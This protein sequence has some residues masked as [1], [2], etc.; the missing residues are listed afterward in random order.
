MKEQPLF[1]IATISY[2]SEKWIRQAIESVLASSISDFEYL[3]SD[4]CSSD[5][6]WNIVSQ[7]NDPRIRSWKNEQNIG[8]YPNRNK[9]L[10]EAKGKYILYV[11]GDDILYNNTLR[12]ASEYVFAFP[13]AVSLW[14]V[15]SHELSFCIFPVL[16]QPAEL[17]KWIYGANLPIAIM[18]FGETVFKTETLKKI[19]GFSEKY[20]SGDMYVKKLIALEGPVLLTPIGYMFWRRSPEQATK[21]LET[22]LNGYINNVIIDREIL[23]RLR[24]DIP[25]DEVAWYEKNIRVRDI[26]VL[27]H[28]TFLKTKFSKGITI[29]RRLKFSI[30]DLRYLLIDAD[31]NY[32]YDLKKYLFDADKKYPAQ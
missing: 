10:N 25:E 12:N 27:F 17:I 9:I 1:T 14:G 3:I 13:G 28:H 7:Y 21:K 8:E 20:I 19:G 24:P 29:W 26:K 18:G 15:W 5:Q 32:K 4:D 11:D 23:S 31:Y 30:S 16:L 22:G 6:T 2:N